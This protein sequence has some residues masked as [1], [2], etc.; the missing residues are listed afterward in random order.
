[1][2]FLEKEIVNLFIDVDNFCKVFIP[3]WNKYLI[4]HGE[5][6]RYK[7]RKNTLVESEIITL[8]VL[9]QI[10]GFKDFKRFYSYYSKELK[11]YFPNIPSYKRMFVLQ[12]KVMIPL[13][14]Y[15]QYNKGKETGVYYVDST[16]I[17]VCKNQRIRRHKTFKGIAKR[18]KSSMGWFYG[19]K[20]HLVINNGGEIVSFQITKGNVFD[21]V[22]LLELVRNIKL[23]GKLFRDKGY[24]CKEEV[25]NRLKEKHNIVLMTKSRKNMKNKQYDTLSEEDKKL[26]SKRNL[27][28]TTI[29]EIKRIGNILTTRI[30][31]VYNYFI[32]ILSN[33]VAY[34]IMVKFG[35]G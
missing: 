33:I 10:S 25:K 9:Y 7:D 18:G 17:P 23:G 27:V 26:L 13:L 6:K 14:A 8:Y 28:E 12:R 20:L 1:M 32:N 11:S 15:A 22:P 19:F 21:N 31:N 2:I 24:L 3:R 5:K 16:P 34:Q 35:M 4:S 30:K 29:G